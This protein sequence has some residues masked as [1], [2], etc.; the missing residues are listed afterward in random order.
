MEHH[1]NDP[2]DRHSTSDIRWTKHGGRRL[3][4][5]VNLEPGVEYLSLNYIVMDGEG[6]YHGKIRYLVPRGIRFFPCPSCVAYGIAKPSLVCKGVDVCPSCRMREGTAF[7][8]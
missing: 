6:R 4:Y 3:I 1:S 2:P 8:T 5:K 7:W